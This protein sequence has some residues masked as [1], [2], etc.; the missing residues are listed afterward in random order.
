MAFFPRGFAFGKQSIPQPATLFQLSSEEALL[1]LGRIQTILKRLHD[2]T[3]S[4]QA[5]LCVDKGESHEQAQGDAGFQPHVSCLKRKGFFFLRKHVLGRKNVP[6]SPDMRKNTGETAM[7]QKYSHRAKSGA[8]L[9]ERYTL[10]RY[11]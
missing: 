8:H 9:M 2:H 5:S 4:L 3:A 11:H 7:G 10:A 6:L 1:L